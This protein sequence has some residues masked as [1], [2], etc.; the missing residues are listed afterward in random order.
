MSHRADEEREDAYRFNDRDLAERED[1]PHHP[2]CACDDC[3]PHVRH[4]A[5]SLAVDRFTREVTFP[6]GRPVYAADD[7]GATHTGAYDSGYVTC[8]DCYQAQ[9][10]RM[11]ENRE[12]AVA[13]R[14]PAHDLALAV[15]P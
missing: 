4:D 8:F 13:D 12:Q 10:R 11:Q 7:D 3:R 2:D 6:C 5:T 1:A 9:Q 14:G 15:T